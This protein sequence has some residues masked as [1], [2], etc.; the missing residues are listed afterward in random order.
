MYRSGSITR[1]ALHATLRHH[2][3]CRC[4]DP[5]NDCANARLARQYWMQRARLSALHVQ[6]LS[7]DAERLHQIRLMNTSGG[8]NPLTIAPSRLPLP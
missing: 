1:L 3:C 2:A 5:R 4:S 8:G 6:R 7:A